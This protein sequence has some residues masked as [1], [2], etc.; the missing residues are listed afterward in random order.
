ME[1]LQSIK[2]VCI[3]SG[4][5]CVDTTNVPKEKLIGMAQE[6][7]AKGVYY[8]ETWYNFEDV[9]F[10]YNWNDLLSVMSKIYDR[11]NPSIDSTFKIAFGICAISND[12]SSAFKMVC[13][14]ADS[15]CKDK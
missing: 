14:L 3:I 9:P 4:L 11:Y 15:I 8:D 12:I 7:I 10:S 13:E 1:N 6:G 2:N 5:L